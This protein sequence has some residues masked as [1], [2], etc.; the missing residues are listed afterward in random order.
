MPAPSAI[1][2]DDKQKRPGRRGMDVESGG[3]ID[4]VDS[5]RTTPDPYAVF[6]G[7]LHQ[8]GPSRVIPLDVSSRLGGS[9]PAAT[10]LA[11]SANFVRIRPGRSP[12]TRTRPRSC[13]TSSAA[14]AAP[15]LAVSPSI[16][17]GASS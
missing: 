16:G 9:V 5:G 13:S 6:P 14:T 2:T 7:D 3:A 12:P 10:G 4:P 8:S 15:V 1:P 17:K 11:L